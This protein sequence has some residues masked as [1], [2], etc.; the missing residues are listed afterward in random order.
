MIKINLLPQRKPKRA[1]D[2]AQ[3]DLGLGLLA[4]GA[5]ALTMYFAV[6]RPKQEQLET[7]RQANQDFQ[8]TINRR[9]SKI[10]G[11]PELRAAVAETEA[12]GAQIDKLIAARAVPAHMLHELGEILTPGRLP[13]MTKEMAKRVS[14]PRN[15]AYRFRED[16][17]PKHVWI[18]DLTE[19]RGVF[20]LEGG[21]ES[22][23]DYAQLMKRMQ[24]S[25]YFQDVTPSGGERVTDK[26]TA[27]TYYKF[28]ITGKVVY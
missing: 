10:R 25:A 23:G 14:D 9:K 2:R 7:L 17:D 21:A 13:T 11:L 5:V 3:R 16:W 6:H 18:T 24:A 8:S 26:T 1:A 20:T 12:R 19:R 22:D 28:T 15:E 27:V 4:L